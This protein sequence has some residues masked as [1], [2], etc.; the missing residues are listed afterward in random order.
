M[1]AQK[2]NQMEHRAGPSGRSIERI[3]IDECLGLDTSMLEQLT[4]WFGGRPLEPVF[5]AARHPGIPDIE[6]LDKLLDERTA[7]LTRD[8]VLHNLALDRGFRSFL[9]SSDG[10][11]INRKLPGVVAHDKA[12]PTAKGGLQANYMDAVSPE[13]QAITGRLAGFL[14][15][16]QLKQFRTKRRRIRAHFGAVDNIAATA[17]T[18]G[19]RQTPR[20][21]VGGYLLKVDARHGAKSLSPASEGYF[22]APPGA[23]KPLQSMIWALAHVLMLRLEKRPLS[24]FACGNDVADA[25]IALITG[26]DT[27][28]NPIE[29]MAI[30][31][32]GA[33]NEP[34]VQPCIKGRFFDRMEAKLVQLAGRDSNELVAIDVPTM[35]DVLERSDADQSQIE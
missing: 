32:L 20:G 6:I 12:L 19:Q 24:L 25:C 3:V 5:L 33:V 13:A 11:L 34:R 30:R 14:S 8:R 10:G 16:H 29:R 4:T 23:E 26:H 27:A 1:P 7:L 9:P 15:E 17:L 2:S 31:L 22:I 35:A 28:R 18:I 21:I